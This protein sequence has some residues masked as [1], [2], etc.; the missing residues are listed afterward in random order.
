MM[1][2]E[3]ILRE[4]IKHGILEREGRGKK[5]GFWGILEVGIVFFE[6]EMV[7]FGQSVGKIG[8]MPGTT[9]PVGI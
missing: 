1:I 7:N 9:R 3:T 8:N 5:L 4:S 2:K 6:V